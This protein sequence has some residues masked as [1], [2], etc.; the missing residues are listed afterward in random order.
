MVSS[1][2][3]TPWLTVT[4][5]NLILVWLNCDGHSSLQLT[6]DPVLEPNLLLAK[7]Q[8]QLQT[9]LVPVA[10]SSGSQNVVPAQQHQCHLETYWKKQLWSLTSTH[11]DQKF[12]R[13]GPVTGVL[14]CLQLILMPGSSLRTEGLKAVCW[15]SF[16]QFLSLSS[17]TAAEM[18]PYKFQ[19]LARSSSLSSLTKWGREKKKMV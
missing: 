8:L 1:F 13:Q 16:C 10:L 19:L 18:I 4:A 12:S 6:L 15:G 11:L 3:A 14:T 7:T 17:Q 2:Y 9:S 5:A